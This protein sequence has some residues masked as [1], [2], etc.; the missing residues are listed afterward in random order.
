LQI[1]DYWNQIRSLYADLD[2]EDIFNA[3]PGGFGSESLP[4]FYIFK[5]KYC[6]FFTG[7]TH[8]HWP[9][10]VESLLFPLCRYML[11]EGLY[12][13]DEIQLMQEGKLAKTGCT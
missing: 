4:L 6:L 7:L 2:P 9:G 3:D 8:H 12:D 13:D 10:V 1:C 11:K 5:P